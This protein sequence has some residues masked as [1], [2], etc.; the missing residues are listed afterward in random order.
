MSAVRPLWRI[1]YSG[2][3]PCLTLTLPNCTN[4]Q[5]R[6]VKTKWRN[7]ST[8]CVCSREKM[9]MIECMIALCISC[10][11]LS[12]LEGLEQPW[13]SKHTNASAS[14]IRHATSDATTYATCE[15]RQ[16]ARRLDRHAE[17]AIHFWKWSSLRWYVLE[18]IKLIVCVTP[19]RGTSPRQSRWFVL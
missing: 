6:A 3:I 4:T 5:I 15:A 8:V 14:A 7:K 10:N 2:I 11:V 16:P 13:K 9:T 1:F 19:S 12:K 18:M 17:N